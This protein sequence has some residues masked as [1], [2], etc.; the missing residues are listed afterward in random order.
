MKT[1]KPW[2]PG[3]VKLIMLLLHVLFAIVEIN[4]LLVPLSSFPLPLLTSYAA[5][6]AL[7]FSS[8]LFSFQKSAAESIRGQLT[9]PKE[10]NGGVI[11]Q[12]MKTSVRAYER[13]RC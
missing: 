7:S 4:I 8:Q 10:W 1:C 12:P 9:V 6:P 5:L 3:F 13:R 2:L 11:T